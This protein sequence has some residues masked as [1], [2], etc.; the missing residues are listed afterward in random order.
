MRGLLIIILLIGATLFIMQ[1]MAVTTI[2]FFKY[3]YTIPR[4]LLLVITL[5]VGILIGL[6][7]PTGNGQK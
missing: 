5:S 7:I 6:L 3:T 4:A 1:S 2:F